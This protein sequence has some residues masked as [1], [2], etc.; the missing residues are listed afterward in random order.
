IGLPHGSL[1]TVEG[2][3]TGA[4]AGLMGALTA[5]MLSIAEVKIILLLFFMLSGL[6]GFWSIHFWNIGNRK[7]EKRWILLQLLT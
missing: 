1:S 5:E 4:M 7:G 2:V 3:F 6:G